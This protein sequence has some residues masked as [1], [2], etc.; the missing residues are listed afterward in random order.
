MQRQLLLLMGRDD[1]AV[2]YGIDYYCLTFVVVG[3]RIVVG[4]A[5]RRTCPAALHAAVAAA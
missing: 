4:A 3:V 2:G 5:V 1:D